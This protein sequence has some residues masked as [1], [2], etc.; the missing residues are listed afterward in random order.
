[1]SEDSGESLVPGPMPQH[2]ESSDFGL[3][4]SSSSAASTNSKSTCAQLEEGFLVCQV[5]SLCMLR[6]RQK[7]FGVG[8]LVVEERSRPE[9]AGARKHETHSEER[10]SKHGQ[11]SARACARGILPPPHLG[12]THRLLPLAI[13]ISPWHWRPRG[14]PPDRLFPSSSI[15][16]HK[17]MKVNER[18]CVRER[19]GFS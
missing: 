3:G 19:T 15:F 9:Q 10:Q 11:G 14:V 18:Q 7:E 4:S 2:N 13:R 5:G 6:A 16:F 12:L 8:G 1:M 17:G